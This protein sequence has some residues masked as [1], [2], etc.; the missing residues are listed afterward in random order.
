MKIQEYVLKNDPQNQFNVL[1]NT[2]QQVESAWNNKID[3]A[4]LK[5]NKFNSII[6]TGLGGS[7]ISADLMANFL[8]NELTIPFLVNRNYHLPSFADKNT[9]LIVSSYS[10]NTEE[11]ISVFNEG[12][13]KKCSI[14]CI[15]TGGKIGKTAS[16]NSIPTVNVVFRISTEIFLGIKF[17]LTIKDITGT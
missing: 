7:A 12:I 6:V 10:G 15:T 3:L 11:T 5:N 2:Y 16:E 14:I 17:F 4:S 1:I 13:R 9:L 8:G